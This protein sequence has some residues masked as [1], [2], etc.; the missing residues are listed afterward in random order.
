MHTTISITP[1][2][3]VET[4]L[5]SV[6]L[7]GKKN[8]TN[9]LKG[10]TKKM[11]DSPLLDP[12]KSKNT[13]S[14][15]LRRY[16]QSYMH[17]NA[18]GCTMKRTKAR[19]GGGAMQKKKGGVYVYEYSWKSEMLFILEL[20]LRKKVNTHQEALAGKNREQALPDE[21]SP[22][23]CSTFTQKYKRTGRESEGNSATHKNS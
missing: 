1:H 8:T 16:I 2:T 15:S 17:Y 9:I 14:A 20:R 19:D 5:I 7:G 22:F 18:S 4:I 12:P 10:Q 11:F 6:M 13:F 21:I 23:L 3:G